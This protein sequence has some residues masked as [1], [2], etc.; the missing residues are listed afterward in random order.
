M[1]CWR[2]WRREEE[3]R[4]S[5]EDGRRK[6]RRRRR[7]GLRR[8]G[9]K[10]AT[11]AVTEVGE[12]EVTVVKEDTMMD[13]GSV[14]AA[15]KA[16]PAVLAAGLG[17]GLVV[18]VTACVVYREPIAVALGQ[19][20]LVVEG[21][22]PKGYLLFVV[23]YTLLE[24]LAVPAAPLTMTAGALFGVPLGASLVLTS[25]TAAA[26]LSFVVTR[27]LARDRVMKL[28]ERIDNEGKWKAVDAAIGRDG[29][30]VVLLLRLSPLLPFALSNYLYGLS[31]VPLNEYAAG[32][33]LGMIPG[34][35]AYVA[36]GTVGKK[37]LLNTEGT[38]IC[39]CCSCMFRTIVTKS[40]CAFV[41]LY[42]SRSL[43]SLFLDRSLYTY[44][45]THRWRR[46]TRVT[47]VRKNQSHMISAHRRQ[48]QLS[49]RR[50]RSRVPG[51]RAIIVIQIMRRAVLTDI[52]IIERSLKPEAQ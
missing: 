32:S 42:S 41:L 44:I 27:Y 22:G 38:H 34:T 24:V 28:A 46:I 11:E 6:R 45:C 30:R 19:F 16:A 9:E 21:L 50:A 14:Q 37:L 4:G 25:A 10:N 48:E 51:R 8:S 17:L 13:T 35:V 40:A 26:C 33:F 12:K 23:V 52:T 43:L 31:S 18:I 36:A 3:R 5:G 39:V 20:M 47:F 2:S 7:S 1:L 15:A 49:C 29:F